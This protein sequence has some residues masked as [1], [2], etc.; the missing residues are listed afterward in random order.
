MIGSM[1]LG[2]WQWF[3][4]NY[5]A[6]GAATGCL[7]RAAAAIRRRFTPEAGRARDFG[8]LVLLLLPLIE[9]NGRVHADFGPNSDAEGCAPVRF[10]LAIWARQKQDTIRPNNQRMRKLINDNYDLIPE[11]YGALFRLQLS[12]I[13][14]F[15]VHCDDPTFD[16]SERRFPVE[17]ADVVRDAAADR[18]RKFFH[19]LAFTSLRTPH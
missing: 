4:Q 18:R 7:G 10:N 5:A 6:V 14:A 15:D 2:L 13:D 12:H 8:H 3:A 11:Q 19:R 1:L 16:Y 9:E 17:F